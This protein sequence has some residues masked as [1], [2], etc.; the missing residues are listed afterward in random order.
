MQVVVETIKVKETFTYIVCNTS[1]LQ[2]IIIDPAEDK[3]RIDFA[4]EDLSPIA[5]LI[6]HHHKDHTNLADAFAIE[7][8]IPVMVSSIEANFYNYTCS[9]IQK[10]EPGLLM[11]K[12]FYSFVY[13]T[14]GHTKGSVCYLIGDS[15][16]SGDTLFIETCGTCDVNKGG[17]PSDMYR[18]VQ[19]LKTALS[20]N[21]AVFPG[22]SYGAYPGKPFSYVIDNNIYLSIHA[23]EDFVKFI[24]RK[25]RPI[26]QT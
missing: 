12:E 26:V 25:H 4:L 10:I 8:N 14:P 11:I 23:E 7:Y 15:I 21:V 24:T 19:M 18:S 5:I 13:L 2:A 9:N 3:P 20:P 6:T 1:T 16:F 22:H 17:S